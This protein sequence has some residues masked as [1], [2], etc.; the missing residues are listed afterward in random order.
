MFNRWS[1]FKTFRSEIGSAWYCALSA[2]IA[3]NIETHKRH[4]LTGRYDPITVEELQRIK[5]KITAHKQQS[6]RYPEPE[7]MA[8]ND[9]DDDESDDDAHDDD[10]APDNR[11]RQLTLHNASQHA[12]AATEKR[13]AVAAAAA[14]AA[15]V[16]RIENEKLQ[17]GDEAAW[18]ADDGIVV[19]VDGAKH[20]DSAA[21]I[22]R[23]MAA[24]AMRFAPF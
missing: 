13:A 24:L 8:S 19:E 14:A 21:A 23:G 17:W 16:Q 18:D 9:D 1:I 15:E 7:Y 6:R 11:R 4:G 12:A 20:G 22:E 2:I 5:L 10:G 3:L